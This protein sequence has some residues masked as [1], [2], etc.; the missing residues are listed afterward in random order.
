MTFLQITDSDFL[1]RLIFSAILTRDLKDC[2]E[3]KK[4]GTYC[5]FQ[6]GLPFPPLSVSC[7]MHYSFNSWPSDIIEIDLGQHWLR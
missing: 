6:V 4:L 2:G 7:S 1:P 5:Q 3:G